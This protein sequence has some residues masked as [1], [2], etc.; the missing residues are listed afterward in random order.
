LDKFNLVDT[1]A[2][3]LLD[4]DTPRGM[5]ATS[6]AANNMSAKALVNPLKKA[7]DRA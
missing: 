7:S 5:R 3:R 1:E 4:L 6:I 2:Q